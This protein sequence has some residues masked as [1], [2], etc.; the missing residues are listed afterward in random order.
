M[1][2]NNLICKLTELYKELLQISEKF[3][4]IDPELFEEVIEASRLISDLNLDSY[5]KTTSPVDSV[6]D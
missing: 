4:N 1:Q 2:N 5:I 6:E 3:E